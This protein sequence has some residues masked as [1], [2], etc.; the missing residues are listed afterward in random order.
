MSLCVLCGKKYTRDVTSSHLKSHDLNRDE[1]NKKK[2]ILSES[3]WNF[4]WSHEGLHGKFPDPL[5][6]EGIDGRMTF[7]EWCRL[8]K[9]QD[10]HEELKV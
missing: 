5:A 1:Y 8:P 9:V 2:D 4:Y 6:T 3:V 7:I 10:K